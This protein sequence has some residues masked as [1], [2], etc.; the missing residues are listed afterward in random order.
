LPPPDWPPDWP[1]CDAPPDETGCDAP[2]DGLDG[3]APGEKPDCGDDWT[4]AELRGEFMIGLL[5]L[6]DRG[7]EY[8]CTGAAGE[9]VTAGELKCWA[10]ATFCAGACTSAAPPGVAA[11][12][13]P[14]QLEPGLLP[15]PPDDAAGWLCPA[16]AP[17]AGWLLP[18]WFT[19]CAGELT[20]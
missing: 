4:G 16:V 10:G 7:L 13:E 17:T 1:G 12:C 19:G 2:R 8:C 14:P 20:G 15:H 9:C 18:G 6:L 5:L 11:E 3:D